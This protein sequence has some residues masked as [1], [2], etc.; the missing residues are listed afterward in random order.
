MLGTIS[1]LLGSPFNTCCSVGYHLV[2]KQG[3]GEL[4]TESQLLRD[5]H[6]AVREAPVPLE[7]MI[8]QIF[9]KKTKTKQKKK[10]VWDR[11]FCPLRT[12]HFDQH[13][14]FDLLHF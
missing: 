9:I 2:Y 10:Q 4:N 7:F 14:S 6:S 13:G 5:F 12:P 11:L 3:F 1:A 8:E